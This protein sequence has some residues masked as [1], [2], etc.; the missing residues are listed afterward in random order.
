MIIF[1]AK[2]K[3]RI[4]SRRFPA[5]LLCLCMLLLCLM[6]TVCI[7][8]EETEAPDSLYSRSCALVDGDTGRVLFGK[9]EQTPMANASTTKIMT[10]ILALEY[11]NMEDVVT[12]SA[13]AA[14]QP[15]VHLGMQEGERFYLEDL[16]YGL[17]LESYNDCAVAIAEQIAGSTEGFAVLMNEKAVELGCEDTYFITPN[18]LDAEDENGFHHTTASDL[19]KIM[20]YCA[21]DSPKA[22]EFC[23]ITQTG[24]YTFQSID[25]RNFSV[26][27]HNAF[28]TMMD[29]VVSGKTGFTANAGYCYV[30]AL[31][32]EGRKF[33]I[34]LLACGWPN[35]RTY[36]WSDARKLFEYGIANYH[37]RKLEE[38]IEI[39]GLYVGNGREAD[40]GLEDWGSSVFIQPVADMQAQ[41]ERQY[42]LK[43]SEDLTY[44]MELAEMLE[45]PLRAQDTVG[46]ISFFLEGELLAEVPVYAGENIDEWDFP[47]LVRM[48][49]KSYLFH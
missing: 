23:R 29:G 21:W 34:A 22:A 33:C 15:K 39:P 27:N 37:Y 13:K 45:S 4:G 32:S 24:S 48:I 35:N 11:G 14:S 17:M 19:C 41:L 28:L 47:F 16:L 5:Y 36:K 46:K 9:E 3:K 2:L 38:S 1:C 8:G 42:L 49:V 6:K 26:N 20:K 43:D 31:E 12:A 40:A 44:E 18:G 25:G 10:C 7:S 30:A